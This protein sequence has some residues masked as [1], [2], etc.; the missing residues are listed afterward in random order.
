[1]TSTSAWSEPKIL[2][3][4]EFRE[5]F[6]GAAT[7]YDKRIGGSMAQDRPKPPDTNA[8]ELLDSERRFRLLVEAVIDYAI[9]MLDPTGIVVN[10][11]TGAERIKGYTADEIVGKSF[12]TFYTPGIARRAGQPVRSKRHCARDAFRPKAGACART[13]RISGQVSSSIRSAGTTAR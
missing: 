13:A 3:A 5:L 6:L 4:Q 9:Y 11:N 8:L 12:E 1:M 2:A 10:W 7:Y